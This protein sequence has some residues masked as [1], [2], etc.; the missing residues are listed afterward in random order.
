MPKR[1]SL[2]SMLPPELPAGC[3]LCRARLG[4]VGVAGALEPSRST[5]TPSDEQ[6]V[7]AASS[8]HPCRVSPANLPEHVGQ[9]ARDQRGS[10]SICRK[11]VSGVGFSNGCAELAL[12][13]PPPL[14]PSFLIA[15]CDATGPW[16]IV[17]GAPSRVVTLRRRLEVLR[18]LPARRSTSAETSDSGSST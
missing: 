5:A 15:S 12:K 18:S 10:R 4:E 6:D 2:P 14:V 3:D 16:A 13:K 1:T 11:F 17:C 9:P 8:T 7:I